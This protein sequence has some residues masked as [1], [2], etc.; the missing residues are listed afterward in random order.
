M[1][2]FLY[3]LANSL[4]PA[5]PIVGG[6]ATAAGVL[7]ATVTSAEAAEPGVDFSNYRV[8]LYAQ[9][10]DH[11]KAK[12]A[13]RLGSDPNPHDRFFI[14]PF[15]YENRGNN[16]AFSH[17][18]MTVIR[19][20]GRTGEPRPVQGLNQGRYKQWDFEAFTVSW[21]PHDFLENPHLCVFEGVGSRVFPSKN[22]CPV[23]V[24]KDFD[25]PQTVK[26]AAQAKVAVGMWGPYEITKEAFDI[27]VRRKRLLDTG[28]IKYRADDRP[29]LKDQTAINCFHALCGLDEL[30]PKGGVFGTGLKMW[31]LNG[32]RR[33]LIEYAAKA[34]KG[35][36]LLEPVDPKRDL[37][38]FVYASAAGTRDVYNPFRNASAYEK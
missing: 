27:A 30:F 1:R 11:I 18:F 17:S 6:I 31:G 13:A 5:L 16:P 25:L 4:R 2:T 26:L 12:V 7:L 24:G 15:G 29:Y 20:Y 23:S 22:N 37:Y 38:G 35:H 33:V 14:I 34:G 3:Q 36:L 9:I 21:L 28:V 32:T 8:P 10:T 19:V